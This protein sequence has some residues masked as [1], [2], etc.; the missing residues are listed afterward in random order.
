MQPSFSF[1]KQTVLLSCQCA[2]RKYVLDTLF[3]IRK[4]SIKNEGW[5]LLQSCIVHFINQN[6]RCA[7]KH[8]AFSLL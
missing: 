6:R 1:R 7:F 2:G 8:E 5:L 4:S 3:K